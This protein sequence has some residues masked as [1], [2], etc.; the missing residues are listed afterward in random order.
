MVAQGNEVV[1]SVSEK[2][3][4]DKNLKAHIRPPIL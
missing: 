4:S 2:Y 3:L 1:V